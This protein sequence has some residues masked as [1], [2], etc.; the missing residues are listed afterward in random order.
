MSVSSFITSFH[1]ACISRPYL[2]RLSD[3]LIE[4]D[5]CSSSRSILSLLDPDLLSRRFYTHT[6]QITINSYCSQHSARIK[7]DKNWH[8]LQ[9]GHWRTISENEFDPSINAYCQLLTFFLC[10]LCYFVFLWWLSN[11]RSRSRFRQD[12][13]SFWITKNRAHT[14]IKL[15]NVEIQSDCTCPTSFPKRR[16]NLKIFRCLL[17]LCVLL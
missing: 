8:A 11:F 1:A 10:Q 12:V 5:T 2:L 13:H 17:L 6:G 16:E 7:P 15:S 4:T 9:L 3:I 14:S